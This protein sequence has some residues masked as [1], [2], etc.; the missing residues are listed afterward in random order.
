MQDGFP[1]PFHKEA[2]ALVAGVFF[3]SGSAI[4]TECFPLQVIR[5]LC[6]A[7]QSARLLP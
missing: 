2:L 7:V 5:D 6:L 1:F 3:L 4:G